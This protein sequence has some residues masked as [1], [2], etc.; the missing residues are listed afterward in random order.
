VRKINNVIIKLF[1]KL[2][3]TN[4]HATTYNGK[5]VAKRNAFIKLG[6]SK[7][8]IGSLVTEKVTASLYNVNLHNYN[9]LNFFVLYA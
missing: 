3:A 2:A 6:N 9:E 8:P 5:N 4:N 7:D 1:T